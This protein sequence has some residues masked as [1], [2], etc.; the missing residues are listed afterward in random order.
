MGFL[1]AFDT[2]HFVQSHFLVAIVFGMSFEQ[3]RE[4]SL[5]LFYFRL[6]YRAFFEFRKLK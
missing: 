6:L 5:N 4:H 1:G 2:H 3:K